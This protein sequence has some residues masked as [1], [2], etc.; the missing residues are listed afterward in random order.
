MVK[1]SHALNHSA[2]EAVT[3]DI[4]F[5]TA[6]QEMQHICYKNYPMK[7]VRWLWR[8][9][10]KR[11]RQLFVDN[12]Q[13]A[14]NVL[15]ENVESYICPSQQ[16]LQL[17]LKKSIQRDT[18]NKYCR[19]GGMRQTPGSLQKQH[20]HRPELPRRDRCMPYYPCLLPAMAQRH[21]NSPN[22]HR[23]NLQPHRR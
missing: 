10:F 8:W 17:Q 22:Q 12:T 19:L 1:V 14:S 18:A 21:G 5:C 2:T 23:T 4:F 9:T 11:H 16:T 7:V 3:D 6:T 20:C 13:T 15:V